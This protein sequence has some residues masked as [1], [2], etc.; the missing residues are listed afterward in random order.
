MAKTTR[1]ENRPKDRDRGKK[2]KDDDDKKKGKKPPS[3]GGPPQ[4]VNESLKA[5]S[6]QTGDQAM[7][8]VPNSFPAEPAN[9]EA[10]YT[11]GPGQAVEYNYKR[12][13]T[14]ADEY[15]EQQ[16]SYQAPVPPIAGFGQVLTSQS[17]GG[18]QAVDSGAANNPT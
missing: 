6:T 8:A 10:V 16:S 12:L 11:T 2:K 15:A 14:Y 3:G 13:G 7:N 18:T 1:T 5:K 9:A 4:T 17:A